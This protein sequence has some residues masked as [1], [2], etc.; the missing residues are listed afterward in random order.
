MKYYIFIFLPLCLFSQPY[1]DVVSVSS[2][3][4][5]ASFKDI[6][7]DKVVFNQ[8]VFNLFLPVSI[9]ESSMLL[10]R[11]NSENI[12][13]NSDLITSSYNFSS[14]ALSFGYQKISSNNIWKSVFLFT[15]K[16]AS[17]F[18]SPFSN[19][20]FQ[21]GIFF[22]ET[23]SKN[24]KFKFKAGIYYNRE[25]FGNFIIPL[26]GIDYKIND[27]FFIYGVLPSNFRF[28]YNVLKEKL[29][30]G[31][32]FKSFTRSFNSSG[33]GDSQ[34]LRYD[35]V[36]LKFFIDYILHKQ[37]LLNFEIGQNFGVTP[38]LYN[39]SSNMTIKDNQYF[40]TTKSAFT[41][42]ASMIYRIRNDK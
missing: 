17:D 22:L 12:N 21:Y 10:F 9:D 2:Q 4:T 14:I 16:V 35:E 13:T 28:E 19:N 29:Y 24:P 27:K 26:L 23:F 42:N 15:P 18:R 33:F 37:F 41:F 25:A 6:P 11:C 3:Y 40:N 20:D 32:G 1:L 7:K 36:Q 5:K 30:S 8:S 38:I 39:H 31:I 34:Y